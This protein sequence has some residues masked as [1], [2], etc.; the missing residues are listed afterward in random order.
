MQEIN[1]NNNKI[2]KD[3][4]SMSLEEIIQ[5]FVSFGLKKYKAEQVFKWLAN[6]TCSF[7]EMTDLSKDLREFLNQKYKIISAKIIKKEISQDG[8]K[9][10]AILFEDGSVVESVLMQYKF[11]NSIC[12]STQVG[13]KMRCKFC[14]NS[15]LNFSR[16]L[17]AS[18]ILTQVQIISRF[19]NINI[20]NIT[21]MGIGEPFDNYENIIKFIKIATC[22]KG[23]NIGAR[24]ISVSTCGIADKIKK[25]ADEN[26][27]ATLSVS[28]HAVKNSLRNKIM[29]IN[30]MYNLE[31]LREACI[32]YNKKTNKRISFEYI[33]LNN[34]ND[35]KLDAEL[36]AKFLKNMIFHV[37]LISANKI[38]SSIL[39]S[40]P[41][42]K[43][44]IF[45]N[46]LINLGINVTVRRTLGSDIN[47]SCGQLRVK[48]IR[49]KNY[50]S[51]N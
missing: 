3:I 19:E 36:L 42:E 49:S 40:S 48:I 31:K 51:N 18:E 1:N 44:H 46:W 28:L 20:S 32:Y 9:K 39:N 29:P 2:K 43:I 5:D 8:T 30:N 41:V 11:G 25:F 47:A 17:L 34:L 33:M 22:Q 35:S 14:A 27:S 4:K 13:C 23:M 26:L 16:N 10:F 38:K 6:F 15:E 45:A 7:D 21:L 50:E 37:N 12:V 24:R